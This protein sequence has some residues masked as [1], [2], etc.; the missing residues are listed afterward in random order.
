MVELGWIQD[1]SLDGLPLS[2]FSSKSSCR[3]VKVAP[4]DADVRGHSNRAPMKKLARS[5]KE[6]IDNVVTYCT[7][8]ITNAVAEGVLA[9]HK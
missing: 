7:H 2:A 4:S 1:D 3:G 8:G 6:R 9:Q 5:L